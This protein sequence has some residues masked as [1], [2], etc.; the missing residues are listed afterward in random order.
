MARNA[1]RSS[2]EGE[3]SSASVAGAA[4]KRGGGGIGGSDLAE[5][6]L[7]APQ[8][9][10]PPVVG[11]SQGDEG[12]YAIQCRFSKVTLFKNAIFLQQYLLLLLLFI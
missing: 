12:S 10:P 6:P 7:E 1:T 11:D 9:P 5:P 8:P 4:D 3:Q 2:S